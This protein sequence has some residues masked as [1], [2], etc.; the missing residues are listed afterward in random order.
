[1][2]EYTVKSSE[3]AVAQFLRY[4][5]VALPYEFTFS[6]KT[7]FERVGFLTETE[8][9]R[10]P[11]LHPHDKQKSRNPRKLAPTN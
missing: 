9:Q 2:S 6:T 7:N 1:M 3:F 10:I 8:I 5:W 4:S 11:K